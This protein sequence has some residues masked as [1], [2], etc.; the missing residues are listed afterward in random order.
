[1]LRRA[2]RCGVFAAALVLS[3]C[4]AKKDDK[5]T[6]P[7]SN[8]TGPIG[9]AAYW[10]ENTSRKVQP[11]TAPGEP[12]GTLSIE[13]PRASVQAYQV[14]LHPTGGGMRNADAT[15]SDLT[16][17]AGDVIAA[18]NV[19]LFREYFIDFS[20]TDM[21]QNLGGVLPAPEDSPTGDARVPDP[22]IPLID[23]YS[24][25]PAG[26]PFG[27][28]ADENQPLWVDVQIPVNATAG[29]YH[30]EITITSDEQ[31]PLSVPVELTVWD[32]T[33]PDSS[34]VVTYFKIDWSDVNA[35][36]SGMDTAY[37]NDNPKTAEYVKRYEELVHTHR[38]NSR[39]TWVPY[40]NG[41]TAPTDWTDFDAVLGPYMDGSHFDD[42]VPATF[43][44][45]GLDVGN[46][47]QPCTHD[48]YVAVA[49]AWATHLKAK[50]WFDQS[51]VYAA[52]EPSPDLYPVIAEQS[53]WLQEADPDFKRQII[54]TT[55][56]RTGTAPTLVPALGVFVLC[57]KCY[58]TWEL[59]DDPADPNSHVYGRA[60]WP[61]L[62]AQGERMWFYESVAQG[63]PYPGFATNTLDAGE[64]QITMW[65]SWYEG[66]SGF[67]YYSVT[68]WEHDNPWGPN[69]SFPK[70]GDG[71]LIY[72][73]NHDGTD[74][75]LGSP[76]NI[77]IDG[78]VPSLR[79][80]MVRAGMQDWGLFKLAADNGLT[81]V[82]RAQ[83]ATAYNQLGGCEWS[84]CNP[85]AWYWKT[86]YAVLGAARHAVADALMNAGVH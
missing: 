72:P 3:G 86:D 46:P 78:P 58:D 38:V 71:V 12:G 16:S 22:L 54:D 77:A 57:L 33:L 4:A 49:R 45:M 35:F 18:S 39:P 51:W 76:E 75:P 62:F 44:G 84:G 50:G 48:E 67:L 70:T 31:D 41:C 82:A 43:F 25:A 32:L 64:P 17:D 40:P 14:V 28:P 53:S 65:G 19:T 6:D 7:N 20:T 61:D 13:G 11:T 79:L 21:S 2:I 10:L 69:V 5:T 52:D 81:D 9:T 8:Y 34:N 60:E 56:P 66:A 42:G 47:D 36:H 26:A 74:Q 83:V 55:M 23:P 80:K 15:A 27:V 63:P 30:G 59:Q 37:P 29:T 68:Q 73:G 85:P 24:G 1:M